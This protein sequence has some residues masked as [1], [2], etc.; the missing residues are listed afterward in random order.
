[1]AG[2]IVDLDRAIPKASRAIL[3]PDV[4]GHLTE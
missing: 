3:G 2:V 1:M 4:A